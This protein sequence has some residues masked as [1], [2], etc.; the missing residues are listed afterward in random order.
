MYVCTHICVMYTAPCLPSPCIN[1]GKCVA[2][3]V[4]YHYCVCTGVYFGKFCEYAQKVSKY[5]S[6]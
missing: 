1:N 5:T 3:N 2:V 4:T 6:A